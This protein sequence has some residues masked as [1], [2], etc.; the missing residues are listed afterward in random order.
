MNITKV[1]LNKLTN[2]IKHIYSDIIDILRLIII[3]EPYIMFTLIKTM[4]KDRLNLY[5]LYK[6]LNAPLEGSSTKI[7]VQ[8]GTNSV[9]LVNKIIVKGNWYYLLDGSYI[10]ESEFISKLSIIKPIKLVASTGKLINNK[11]KKIIDNKEWVECTLRLDNSGKCIKIVVA[12]AIDDR[13][14]NH[15]LTT[16]RQ[17]VYTRGELS[18]ISSKISIVLYNILSTFSMNRRL[19]RPIA[20]NYDPLRIS[21]PLS[22]TKVNSSQ[23]DSLFP[24]ELLF[25]Y[26]SFF[27]A[28][29]ISIILSV[30]VISSLYFLRDIPVNKYLFSTGSLILFTYLLLSGFVFFI[31]KYRYG[32]YTTAMHRF[33]RRSFSI[34]WAL[35]GFLFVVF[36]YLTV[37]SNQEP[38]FMYDNLQFFKTYTYSWR[39]F[40]SENSIILVIVSLLHYV[41][42][43]YKDITSF[44]LNLLVATVT[45]IF[46]FLT[47]IEFYQFFYTISHYN[48][49]TWVFDY[50]S[51]K[52]VLDFETT[53]TRRTRILLHFITICLIAKFW[54]FIFILLFWVFTVS[55][56]IQLKSLSYQL[57]GANL[58]NA[59]ILYL[60]NWI[61]MYP[62][63][64]VA[65]R[66]FL[67]RHY[68]WLYVHFR[69]VGLRVAFSD[70][71]T[72]YSLA[73]EVLTFNIIELKMSWLFL[74]YSIIGSDLLRSDFFTPVI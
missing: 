29:I 40:L 2:L 37:L 6:K 19:E 28:W 74:Y 58:Q 42:V 3:E 46:L 48:P 36:M 5:T 56:L 51:N 39:L 22:N 17:G 59:I 33:W 71:F 67:F 9:S 61:L 24:K 62:W 21:M 73:M 57:V 4:I 32:K 30:C 54:H 16:V 31:K 1:T 52:W 38:F 7:F 55:K 65:F 8:T 68:K 60:L 18:Y 50:E 15:L 63:L 11:S 10:S 43:R 20:I 53:Q 27:R 14:F 34:F 12:N 35:E 41:V 13:L 66:K 25:S 47:Y 45:L 49:T 44:K 72:Y 69:S 23:V 64:K 70:L 26:V